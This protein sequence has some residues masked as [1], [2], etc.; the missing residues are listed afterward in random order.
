MRVLLTNL[1]LLVLTIP[2]FS[3]QGL[4]DA[5]TLYVSGKAVVFFGPS[6]LEYIFMTDQEKNAIDEEL[7][8]FY[9]YRGKVLPFLATY[10]I[11]EFS[12]SRPKIQ[13]QLDNR[14]SIS[15]FRKDFGDAIGLILTDGRQP[16]KVITG[17]TTKA[18]LI[19][20]F[21]EFFGLESLVD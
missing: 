12:T 8:D 5:N 16:P 17:A 4:I 18:E 20:L 13:I 9:H 14:R 1:I 6:Q 21:K 15:Y 7:Y 10:D 19:Q 2:A 11:Q 3:D